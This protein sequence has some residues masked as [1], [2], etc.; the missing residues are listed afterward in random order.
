MIDVS[1]ILELALV[2]FGTNAAVNGE[3][4]R[5]I[6][7]LDDETVLYGD[8]IE[9]TN[10]YC[11]ALESAVDALETPLTTGNSGDIITI[12]NRT[13]RILNQDPD[14]KGGVIITLEE[15]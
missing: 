14:E 5:V 15:T 4:L 10:P 7:D 6:P 12:L 8:M 2:D 13:F 11:T 1:E 3:T 9:H